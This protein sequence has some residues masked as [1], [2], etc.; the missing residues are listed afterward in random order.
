MRTL[1]LTAAAVLVVAFGLA[2][3]HAQGAMS[4]LSSIETVDKDGRRGNLAYAAGDVVVIDICAA[5]SDPCLANAKAMSQ[6]CELLCGDGVT[7]VS[8]L[9]DELGK[10]AVSSYENILGV[11]QTVL[12][13]GPNTIAG[14]S[15]LG[16]M[17]GIPRLVIFDRD[18]KV[19]EN[20]TG[21]VI[22]GSGLIKRVT[23]I[24]K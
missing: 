10:E 23:E 15:V 11:K 14:Q 2:C 17:S 12:L 24:K 1:K 9:L 7:M 5:W 16:D 18:G 19:K 22:S 3:A 6:A 4:A 20:L 21:A 8:I 13:P